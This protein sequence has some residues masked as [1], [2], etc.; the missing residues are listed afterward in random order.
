MR[1]FFRLYMFRRR[2]PSTASTANVIE[3]R[4]VYYAGSQISYSYGT[5][6]SFA[7]CKKLSALH[8]HRCLCTSVQAK[9][10]WGSS[11]YEKLLS[12][13]ETSLEDDCV[14]EAW[15]A[16]NNFKCLF[17]FPTQQL[18][19][20]LIISSSYTSNVHWLRKAYD[21]VIVILKEKPNLLRHETLTRVALSLARA[22]LPV[23]AS[24]ILRV[25]LE[26]YSIPS[27]D[28][29]STLFSHLVKTKVGSYLAS[30]I[31]I[32]ICGHYLH[33]TVDRKSSRQG[34]LVIPSATMFN[35]VLDSCARF[36]SVLKAQQII[37]LMS[38]IGVVADANS[39]VAFARIYEMI[40]QR[41]ELK[42]LKGHIDDAPVI[43][44]RHYRQFYDCL[45]SL[46]FKYN[47]LDAAAE[48]L[49]DLC[50]CSKSLHSSDA[51]SIESNRPRKP[52]VFQ[53]GSSNL[54]TGYKIMVD[55]EKLPTDLVFDAQSHS[56]LV[57]FMD[58]KL[59]P[60]NKAMAN[61]I[62]GYVKAR[63][64]SKLSN[65]LV[66]MEKETKQR[67][68][69]LSSDVIDS[70]IQLGWF[71]IAHDILD[72]LESAKIT[73]RTTSYTSLLR[74]YCR[75]NM[76]EESKVLLKQIRKVGHFVNLSDEDVISSFLREDGTS[77]RP[78]TRITASDTSSCLVGFLDREIRKEEPS[79]PL[80][81]E[82]NASILFFCKAKMMEDAL[83]TY[84]LMEE[85]NVQPTV[86][87]FSHLVNGYASLKA[88][89]QIT[90]LWGE[91]R[92][93]LEDTVLP[94]DRDLLECLLLNF[95]RGGY[96]ERVMEIV[97]FMLKYKMYTDK[98]KYKREFL[99]FHKGLYRNLK[100][101]DA[102]T[103]AQSKRLEQVR[104]F[105]RWVGIYHIV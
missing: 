62:Y 20:K 69:S 82:L 96:F 100:Q 71:E 42:K 48:L 52:C 56:G 14:D 57:L 5:G 92:K 59:F 91:I 36:G 25:M 2:F 31:L 65:L 77:C 9:F 50:R 43:L 84:K 101:S 13:L 99:K 79:C 97:N 4:S 102:R 26:K 95:L 78:D 15:E 80:I 37:Q 103:D 24:K 7:Y 27:S 90:I 49:L 73:I 70:C 34:K 44:N 10:P 45:L 83:K 94:A 22:Q 16:F 104:A 58:G 55:L 61:I 67:E 53:I 86:L 41:D 11:S 66:N 35:L 76:L 39:I 46:H 51:L 89:R 1:G 63:K 8:T 38:C 6:M 18:A 88:Y 87:T 64:S 54:K 93:R 47:D 17:G 98:W 74:A 81:Y 75:E 32:E 30:E 23:S 28:I 33:R 29:W 21:L 105:R 19:S 40:G 85:R 60:T 72:D 12:K 68:P 3:S